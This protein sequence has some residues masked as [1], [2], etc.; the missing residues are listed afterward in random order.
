MHSGKLTQLHYH[1]L[2]TNP[3]CML[4]DL[5]D[6]VH[7]SN[8]EWLKSDSE[9]GNGVTKESTSNVTNKNIQMH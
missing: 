8:V 6:A 9:R 2:S 3:N 4:L 1:A 7:W 5:E